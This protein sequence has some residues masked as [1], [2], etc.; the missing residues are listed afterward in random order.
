MTVVKVNL[1]EVHEGG[2]PDLERRFAQRVG[3]TSAASGFLGAELLRPTTGST[4]FSV[5]R[6]ASEE[7]FQDFAAVAADDVRTGEW[8]GDTAN[9]RTVLSFDVVDIEDGC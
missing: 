9:D 5:S 1:I 3:E 2:G 4:Y 7:A 8:R 6:W